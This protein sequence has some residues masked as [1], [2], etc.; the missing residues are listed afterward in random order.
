MD[1]AVHVGF[2]RTDFVLDGYAIRPTFSPAREAGWQFT[3]LSTP[4]HPTLFTIVLNPGVKAAEERRPSRDWTEQIY[5]AGDYYEPIAKWF[6]TWLELLRRELAATG[7]STERAPK[8]LDDALPAEALGIRSE[9]KALYEKFNRYQRMSGLFWQTGHELEEL[10]RDVFVDA[11]IAAVL[12][13]ESE[14]DVR[15]PLAQNRTLYVEVTGQDGPISKAS[16]KVSQATDVML[17]VI[18][19][20][21]GDR[22]VIAL[23]AYKK[24]S[25]SER[26]G[27]PLLTAHAEQIMVANGTIVIPTAALYDVW[28]LSLKDKAKAKK[29]LEAVYDAPGGTLLAL[30]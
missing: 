29:A 2:K 21:S 8:W 4:A 26:S 13:K 27:K 18:P 12:A 11:G 3:I 25:P 5:S 19:E 23:N 10:V 1:G 16:N 9:A 22:V 30:V 15:V 28:L 20:G 7:S 17:R 14:F 6:V 24:E